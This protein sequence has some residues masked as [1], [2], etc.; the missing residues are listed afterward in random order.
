MDTKT[1][2]QTELKND[3]SS[4]E[5]KKKH[6]KTYAVQ[7]NCLTNSNVSVRK[8][9]AVYILLPSLVLPVI[10]ELK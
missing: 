10:K 7:R 3:F 9:S 5:Q 8:N 4:V 2:T 6:N 1:M